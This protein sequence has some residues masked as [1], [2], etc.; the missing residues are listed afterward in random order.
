MACGSSFFFLL[1]FF[2]LSWQRCL[3]L[4]IANTSSDSSFPWV[5]PPITSPSASPLPTRCLCEATSADMCG[6]YERF[7]NRQHNVTLMATIFVVGHLL[8]VLHILSYLILRIHTLSQLLWYL[9]QLWGRWA[10]FMTLWYK[11]E[12]HIPGRLMTCP[13]SCPGFEPKV[14]STTLYCCLR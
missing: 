6:L 4:S 5:S 3:L 10:V 1:Y 2:I 11:W 7:C 13:R 12:N 8:N 9:P 14:L